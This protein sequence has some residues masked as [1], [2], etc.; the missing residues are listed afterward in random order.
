MDY[1]YMGYTDSKKM[2]EG[3]LVADTMDVARRMLTEQ[4][5]RILEL[6][7]SASGFSLSKLFTDIYRVKP[8][9]LIMFSRQLA[10][11][12]ESGVDIITALDLLREQVDNKPFKKAL[13]DISGD[14]R[15]GSALAVAMAKHPRVFNNLY[16]KMIAVGEKTGGLEVVARQIADYIEREN[17]AVKKV[18]NALMYPA[19][20]I[21]VAI[22]VGIVLMMVALPP[23]VSMFE[24]LGAELP[25]PTRIL[26]GLC[27]FMTDHGMKLILG[28]LIA[29]GLLYTWSRTPKGR[30]TIHG[31]LLRIPVMGRIILLQEISRLCRSMSLLFRGGLAL[32]E[33]M[34]LVIQSC[35]NQ[36]IAAALMQIRQRMLA[37]EGLA[38]PIAAN[39]IFPAL[40]VQ[41]VKI[42]EET[43]SLDATLITVAET[44]ETEAA[45]KTANLIRLIEPTMT[46]L[47]AGV[48]GFIAIAMFMPMYSVLSV[49]E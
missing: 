48:V 9:H 34:A 40:M 43:G 18:K 20:V 26:I 4:G 25:L 11:L 6:K 45:D 42:G 10:L 28:L 47:I 35:N 5:F 27:S 22:V 32:P 38:R 23:M 33:I 24:S 19:V 21:V 36:V 39:A 17:S 7:P 37:G 46:I 29:A 2:I 12:I 16:C 44:Y 15:G 31:L 41:M 30:Y 8:S 1:R 3:T 14:L 49:V 13:S